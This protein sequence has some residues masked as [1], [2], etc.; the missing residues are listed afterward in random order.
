[1]W[2]YIKNDLY[3]LF[4]GTNQLYWS[5]NRIEKLVLTYISN[6]DD[7]I[8]IFGYNSCFS[9]SFSSLWENSVASIFH[10]DETN[11]RGREISAIEEGIED[12]NSWK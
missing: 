4:I 3:D 1:M 8:A 7:L 6:K 11:F 12:G 9:N 10:K 5:S 2:F